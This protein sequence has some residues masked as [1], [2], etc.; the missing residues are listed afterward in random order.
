MTS[1]GT[2]LTEYRSR[3]EVA[4]CNISGSKGLPDIAVFLVLE[5]YILRVRQCI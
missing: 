2:I 1:S 4:V 5:S 3:A